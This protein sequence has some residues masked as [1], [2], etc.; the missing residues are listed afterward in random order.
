LHQLFSGL[1]ISGVF[2][3][4]KETLIIELE[5]AEDTPYNA[6]KISVGRDFPYIVPDITSR[7]LRN[8]T[9]LFPELTGQIIVNISI[10]MGNRV[11]RIDLS[12]ER[13]KLWIILFPHGANIIFENEGKLIPFKTNRV[14]DQEPFHEFD[15][16]KQLSENRDLIEP[17]VSFAEI[18]NYC[19]V[20]N[21]ILYAHILQTY[22]NKDL[23]F[24]DHILN[25]IAD[26]RKQPRFL[27]FYN[28]SKYTFLFSLQDI[29]RELL[30]FE[31][32][33]LKKYKNAVDVL[34][35]IIY[36]YR[37]RANILHRREQTLN[38][39]LSEK[40]LLQK[41]LT[42]LNSIKLD[43]DKAGLF[44]I[45]ADLIKANLFRI[46]KGMEEITVDNFFDPDLGKM[47]ISL[48]RNL[49][50]EQNAKHYY[51]KIKAYEQNREQIEYRKNKTTNK[52]LIING[53]I[54]KLE[55]AE[56]FR[57]IK[58]TIRKMNEK[59]NSSLNSASSP[60]LKGVREHITSDGWRILVGKDDASNDRL[61]FKIGKN[62][63]IWMHAHGVSGS[64]VLIINRD[65]KA[66]VPKNVLQIAASFAAFYSKAKNAKTVPIIYTEVRYVR[67]PRGAKPGTVY[68]QREKTIFA[69]PKDMP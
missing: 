33:E 49:D 36:F 19:R 43:P 8:S 23:P 67:K 54:E 45:Y 59:E 17:Q 56:D 1:T 15:F 21:K 42:T 55:T 53:K 11:L 40:Q 22:K 51:N 6:L 14:K 16:L 39:L 12:D 30:P 31:L 63:D 18:R 60:Y 7:K 68:C 48:K 24:A 26:I 66:V 69:Q 27:V 34:R 9:D 3:Q 13:Y 61:S 52:L 25:I 57:E 47:K 32:D 58:K 64:H 29:P 28:K 44:K 20:I 37:Y 4:E 62:K 50:P 2:T 46:R 38:T 35:D 5:S 65:K 10:L 41:R